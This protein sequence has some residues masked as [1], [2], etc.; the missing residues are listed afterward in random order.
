MHLEMGVTVYVDPEGKM[1][2]IV[3]GFPLAET[4]KS[5]PVFWSKWSRRKNKIDDWM[6]LSGNFGQSDEVGLVEPP[7]SIEEHRS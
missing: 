2:E 3:T 5:L 1:R 7:P 6:Y 4:E